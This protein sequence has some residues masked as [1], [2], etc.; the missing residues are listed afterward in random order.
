MAKLS[1]FADEAA[2]DFSAQLEFL[3]KEK[4][5]YIELR[6]VNK[7]NIMDLSKAELSQARR[8]IRDNELKV[9]AIGSPIGK[10]KIDEPF[11]PHLDKFK[12]AM[13]LAV[14]FATPLIRVFSYYPPDG[15]DIADFRNEVMDRMA[16]KARLLENTN[17][18]MVHENEGGIYG[19]AAERCVDIVK[20]VNSP[21][22][23]LAYD[24][25]NFVYSMNCPNN[26]ETCWPL[27]KPYVEH[28]H[29]KDR[30]LD[31]SR[32]CIPGRGAAQIKELFV[33]L[34]RMDYQRCVTL[35]P[36]LTVSDIMS[37]FTGPGLFSQTIEAIRN[38]AE[39]VGLKLE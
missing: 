12:R 37:G 38:L 27:M 11:E 39:E 32:G 5:G 8:M 34:S 29:I 2:H 6:L 1:A 33:E 30:K 10:V 21:R 18:I 24:A 26:V 3:V 31:E 19:Q 4:I 9:S 28:I 15:K 14:Y 16:A 25:G 22:L 17:L 7:K 36:H 13:D 23:R 20:T 35:E